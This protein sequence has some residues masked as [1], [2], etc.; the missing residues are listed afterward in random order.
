MAPSVEKYSVC[1]NLAGILQESWC[2]QLII[3]TI[4]IPE[5]VLLA[6]FIFHWSNSM[7][8]FKAISS[9]AHVKG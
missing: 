6:L 8:N 1:N 5:L 7:G 3:L 2:T 4:H 9:G